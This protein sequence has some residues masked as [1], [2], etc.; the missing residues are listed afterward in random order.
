MGIVSKISEDGSNLTIAVEG[1]F[2]FSSHSIFRDSYK[3]YEELPKNCT[4]DLSDTTY[5]DSSAL[6]MLLLFRDYAGDA[7]NLI[8]TNPSPQVK[9]ILDIANFGRIFVI[10]ETH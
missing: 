5:L 1:R 9:K 10:S 6:G 8:I 2:D 7:A 4:I 3:K